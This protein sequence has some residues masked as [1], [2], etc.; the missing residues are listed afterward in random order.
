MSRTFFSM[1]LRAS[2][3]DEAD[4]LRSNSL[5]QKDLTVTTADDVA[6]V[7]RWCKLQRGQSRDLHKENDR[8]SCH[9][10]RAVAAG[11]CGDSP[12]ILGTDTG[13]T[14]FTRRKDVIE[15]RRVP[16]SCNCYLYLFHYRLLCG[17]LRPPVPLKLTS[18]L[19][20]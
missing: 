19:S 18:L 8:I 6:V 12:S 1:S 4:R 20:S 11:S 15:F 16:E 10:T 17:G 7:V 9:V 13:I 2:V 5:K 3:R 14:S